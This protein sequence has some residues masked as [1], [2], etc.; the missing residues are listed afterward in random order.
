MGFFSKKEIEKLYNFRRELHKYPELSGEEKDTAERLESFITKYNPDKIIKSLGGHGLAFI[1]GKDNKGPRVMIRADMDALPIE[2][3]NTFDHRSLNPGVGHKCGHDG[4]MAILCGIAMHLHKNPPS[5]GKVILLFQP[6]EETGQGAK[7][8]IED[9]GFLDLNPDYIYALHNLPGFEKNSIILSNK[10]FASASIGTIISLE[11]ESSHAAHPEQGN[12]PAKLTAELILELE[13]L[14]KLKNIFIDFILVTIIHTTIGEVAFGTNPGKATLMAT[15]RSYRNDDMLKL[16]E[17]AE[18]IVEDKSKQYNII[19]SIEYTEE[20]PATI[21][22]AEANEF[23]H[24]AAKKVNKP[25]TWIDNPFRW[26]EDFGN[27]TEKYK[28]ALWGLGSGS[29]HPSL[30]NYDY[31]FPDDIIETGAE[32][33]IRTIDMIF[34]NE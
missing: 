16:K 23:L 27:F 21:N 28:C 10:H 15:F 8:V 18:K 11:G 9:P 24:N 29:K 22:N 5:N 13:N 34:N 17:I 3:A 20:F 1:F 2:E 31:D 6:A 32:V 19:T 25:I 14:P 7:N 12:S 33:F 30:H 4:H 26:S